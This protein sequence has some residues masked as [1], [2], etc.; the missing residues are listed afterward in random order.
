MFAVNILQFLYNVQD[1]KKVSERG[2]YR[3][4]IFGLVDICKK[5]FVQNQP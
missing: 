1:V 5:N 3:F 2:L 4:Y